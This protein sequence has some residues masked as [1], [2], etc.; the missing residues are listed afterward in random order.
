VLT[1]SYDV[2]E[3]VMASDSSLESALW[4]KASLITTENLVTDL[5]CFKVWLDL[6]PFLPPFNF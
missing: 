1:I 5:D 4:R 6:P 2:L 3:T